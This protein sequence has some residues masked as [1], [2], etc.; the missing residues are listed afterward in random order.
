MNTLPNINEFINGIRNDVVNAMN[1]KVAKVEASYL[2]YSLLFGEGVAVEV[3]RWNLDGGMF[4]VSVEQLPAIRRALGR[5]KL[6]NKYP[7]Q[8][9]RVRRLWFEL[10]PVDEAFAHLSFR[11]QT[12]LPKGAKCRIVSTRSTSNYKSL[13][14]S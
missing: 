4:E 10:R 3:S 9:K 11:Y 14:C 2:A 7:V 6:V 12:K 5:L 1:H 13:V 8:R